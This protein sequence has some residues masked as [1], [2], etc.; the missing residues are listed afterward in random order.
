MVSS[1][2]N[3]LLHPVRLRILSELAGKELS[4]RQ[5]AQELPDIP[6]A[7]LYRHIGILVENQILEVVGERVVNGA[8][9]RSYAI[10]VG[11]VRLTPEDLRGLPAEEHLRV[12]SVYVGTLIES[13]VESMNGRDPD[14]VLRDGLSYNRV[15]IHLSDEEVAQFRSELTAIIERVWSNPPAPNRKSYTLA[16]VVIPEKRKG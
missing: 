6:Q 7:S 5:L 9:E 15:T 14:D 4:P 12:F 16:S 13:F 2:T 8:T 1:K 3:L 11:A 10:A